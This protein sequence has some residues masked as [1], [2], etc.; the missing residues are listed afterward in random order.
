[1]NAMN[2]GKAVAAL[3]APAIS[4]TLPIRGPEF[5]RP[6]K[7]LVERLKA[8]GSAT[9]SAV[10]HRMGLRQTFIAGPVT[11]QPGVKVA[12]PVV[13]LQFLPKREDVMAGVA[14]G[15]GEEHL[16]KL[17][18]CQGRCFEAAARREPSCAS[19]TFT[20]AAWARC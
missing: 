5:A 10:M 2:D 15:V 1:M 4:R 13:T 9:A 6:D 11:R 8:V 7:K 14:E 3:P 19:A 12:G 20:P 16:E 18:A 17:N